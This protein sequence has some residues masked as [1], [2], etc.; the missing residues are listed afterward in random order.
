MLMGVATSAFGNNATSLYQARSDGFIEDPAS[1]P[2]S[3]VAALVGYISG[4]LVRSLLIGVAT[5]LRGADLRRLP[6][7]HPPYLALA[8]IGTIARFTALGSGG[9]PLLDRL[10]TSRPSSGTW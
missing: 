5:L 1:S 9:G 3:A 7:E 10:G 2:M 4:G 6:V 8:L